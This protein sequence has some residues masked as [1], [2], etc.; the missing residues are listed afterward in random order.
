MQ[1]LF[2][3]ENRGIKWEYTIK[4]FNASR[5]PEFE[6]VYEEYDICS[7]TCGGG[8]KIEHSINCLNKCNSLFLGVQISKVRCYEKEAGLV[9]EKY[10]LSSSEKPPDKRRICNAHSCP[11]RSIHLILNH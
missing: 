6:W 3:G 11:A 4:D 10:C 8:Q 7:R 1:I 2:Q 9:G 5:S